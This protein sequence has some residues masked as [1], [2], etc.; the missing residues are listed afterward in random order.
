MKSVFKKK[1]GEMGIS[2][3]GGL[4]SGGTRGKQRRKRD[5]SVNFLLFLQFYFS[6]C[7]K[8]YSRG[9]PKHFSSLRW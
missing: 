1:V 7:G 6:Q 4:K 8:H 2:K 3:D 9:E 5:K